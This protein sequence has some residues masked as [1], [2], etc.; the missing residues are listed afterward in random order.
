MNSSALPLDGIHELAANYSDRQG[1]RVVPIA[2]AMFLASLPHPVWLP[3]LP[4]KIDSV[5]L[6]AVCGVLGYYLIGIYYR[7]RFGT[8]QEL[9]YDG[10]P[11]ALQIVLVVLSFFGS[12]AIDIVAR[13]PLF[14]SGL[15]IAAWLI[16]VSWSSR[17]IRKDYAA[18]AVWLAIVSILFPLIGSTQRDVA[19]FY[20]VNFAVALLFAGV[21]DHIA[22]VRAFPPAETEYD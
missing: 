21:H 22:L 18:M 8:V 16:G 5:L 4:P 17:R 7:R 15:V 6:T 13:P 12:L 20:A 9:P 3:N 11:I 1:L 14:L 2:A 19:A 10:V